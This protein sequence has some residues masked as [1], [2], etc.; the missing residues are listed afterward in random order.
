MNKRLLVGTL[1]AFMAV[2]PLSGNAAQTI[3]SPHRN[4]TDGCEECH[5]TNYDWN[6]PAGTC[7]RCH[8]SNVPTSDQ[9]A[10][11]L[12]VTHRNMK[13]QACHNPHVSLQAPE[14]TGG[15]FTGV[16]YDAGTGKSTLTGVTPTPDAKWAAKT[17]AERGMILW[18]ADGTE[19]ESYEVKAI[20]ATAG[21][22]TVKGNVTTTSRAFD[23]RRGQ[24]IAQ[25]VNATVGESYVKGTLAVQFPSSS[26]SPYIYVDTQH[27]SSPTGVCQVCHTA[28]TYW[29]STGGGSQHHNPDPL[30]RVCTDCHK[31]DTGFQATACDGCHQ[32]TGAD[33]V[34]VDMAGMATNPPTG[35]A[36]AGAHQKHAVD[37]A[38]PCATCHT[39]TGMDRINDPQ[40]PVADGKIQIGFNANAKYALGWMATYFGQGGVTYEGTNHTKVRTDGTPAETM[41]CSTVYCHSSGQGVRLNCVTATTNSSPKWD[42]DGT[43]PA[44]DPQ[45]DTEKC[46]NCHGFEK[47]KAN[48]MRTGVH[49]YH[50]GNTAGTGQAFG[51]YVCHADTA[52]VVGTPSDAN[53]GPSQ[54]STT[55]KAKHANGVY[56]VKGSG[57]YGDPIVLD[58][59]RRVLDIPTNP[60]TWDPA[61][62]TCAVACH[63]YSTKQ[64]KQKTATV[65]DG[66]DTAT[67]IPQATL[68]DP[69]GNPDA[70]VNLDPVMAWQVTNVDDH[71]LSLVDISV[72]PDRI[73]PVK[74][75]CQAGGFNGVDGQMKVNP[76]DATTGGN[77][78]VPAPLQGAAVPSGA[79]VRAYPESKIDRTD[80]LNPKASFRYR[81]WDNGP[82]S[83]NIQATN[84]DGVNDGWKN[85]GWTAHTFTPLD[86]TKTN[87]IP[88]PKYTTNVVKNA[89]GTFTLTITDTSL[90]PDLHDTAKN[91]Y[92]GG[93]HLDG[94]GWARLT[95]TGG[96][97]T[98]AKS[99]MVFDGITANTLSITIPATAGLV[100]GSALWYQYNIRDSHYQMVNGTYP[101][102]IIYSGWRAVICP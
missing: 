20:D 24:L 15:A 47:G 67:C 25:K 58:S 53:K 44:G 98:I 4:L 70:L 61:T 85:M 66:M 33:G 57:S 100:S 81:I 6:E 30:G 86:M 8:K 68:C 94:P 55:G 10:A 80:P 102:Y 43:T 29:T 12:A 69:V 82:N 50:V 54:I 87:S 95:Y 17:S 38:F 27:G 56:D 40:H 65:E 74:A 84:V 63:S 93:G 97:P 52:S 45:G 49:Y 42:W 62:K 51:C 37:Y 7:Q 23:L 83:V 3:D 101:T 75:L 72:D 21:T 92:F 76:P 89:N 31:H 79:V 90:D 99:N 22:V 9:T 64:W 2:A 96:S 13:C 18:V 5:F 19:N 46:N 39:G 35:S 77:Y 32:G 36:T 71:T 59:T 88:V 14:V 28:T 48:P 41:T 60:L 1:F 34:P 73:D 91:A 11:P 26:P 78:Q 16:T